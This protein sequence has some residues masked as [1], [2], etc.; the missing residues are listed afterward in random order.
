MIIIV[1]FFENGRSIDDAADFLERPRK[2]AYLRLRKNRI[3]VLH[4]HALRDEFEQALSTTL[5]AKANERTLVASARKLLAGRPT[6][7][8]C[9]AVRHLQAM[10][11][12][13]PA[14]RSHRSD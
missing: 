5:S 1:S 2:A 14:Y 9:K 8:V 12:C 4:E 13:Q 7:N 6:A 11:C 10:A 3:S